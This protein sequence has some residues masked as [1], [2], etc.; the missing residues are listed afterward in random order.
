MVNHIVS[1]IGHIKYIEITPGSHTLES[2]QDA[3][4]II[5]VCME[6]GTQRILIHSGV[7]SGDFFKLRTGIAGIF[8]QKFVN[9]SITAAIIAD[10]ANIKGSTFTDMMTE[11]NKGDHFRFFTDGAAAVAWLMHDTA[12]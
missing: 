6:H 10:P 2:D 7:F 5:G 4:D 12:G 8:Q 11:A 3:A 9:Y 1:E